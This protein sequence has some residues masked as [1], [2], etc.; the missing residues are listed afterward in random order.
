[1]SV[2]EFGAAEDSYLPDGLNLARLVGVGASK[3]AMAK[4]AAL[5]ESMV[6]N[7]ND[8]VPEEGV[9]SDN[10][11]KMASVQFDAIIMANTVDYLTSPRELYK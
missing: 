7:L 6:V 4:N 11:K 8:V 1:M 2:L 3:S 5:S 10:L 9:N